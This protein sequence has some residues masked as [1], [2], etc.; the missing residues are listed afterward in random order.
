MEGELGR[1]AYE[2]EG[3]LGIG[4]AGKLYL[5]LVA[6]LHADVGFGNTEGVDAAA[7]GADSLIHDAFAQFLLVFGAEGDLEFIPR[8]GRD[9][10]TDCH[11]SEPVAQQVGELF[12]SLMFMRHEFQRSTVG[13]A[14]EAGPYSRIVSAGTDILTHKGQRLGHGLIDVGAEREVYA[15]AKIETQVYG[16]RQYFFERGGEREEIY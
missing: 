13:M 12:D 2:L 8:S 11:L 7:Q 4:D 6:A 16:T 1:A 10:R 9:G 14:E 3:S 15:A 5:Y